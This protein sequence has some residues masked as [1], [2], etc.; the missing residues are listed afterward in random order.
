MY[1]SFKR[2][3]KVYASW[4]E[5]RS[6][7]KDSYTKLQPRF[8]IMMY[9]GEPIYSSDSIIQMM[10]GDHTLGIGDSMWIVSYLR[11]MWKNKDH[12]E[13]FH[14]VTTEY[15]IPFFKQFLPD[16]FTFHSEYIEWDKFAEFDHVLPGMY[17]WK[18]IADGADRSW[19][20][21]KSL[22][23]RMFM[24]AGVPYD[25]LPNWSEFTPQRIL[26]PDEAFYK[27]LGILKEDKYVFFQ[28]HSSGRP[29]NLPPAANIRI[30]RHI[31]K[32]YKLK[33]YIIGHLSCLGALEEIDGVVNLSR[34]TE[35][36]D[37]FSLAANAEFI[38][39]PDSAGV[40]LSEA[41]QVP[42]VC[43]MSVLPPSYIASKYKIPTF[44]FGRGHCPHKPCGVVGALPKDKCPTG[45]KNYCR[46]FDII[47]LVQFD[48]CVTK[49][50]SNILST[51]GKV[52]AHNFYDAMYCPISLVH[53]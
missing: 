8:D 52:T 34:K 46:V 3:N 9:K 45:T 24:W 12:N 29:K 49:S 33:V 14:F 18:E 10:Q 28:W 13:N 50:Y 41:Y 38:V 44:M 6:V 2:D 51:P 53:P 26:E 19:L 42:C 39:C 30:I 40:H 25:G 11:G 15:K 5:P 32:K 31:I 7:P 23:E 4:G 43:L 22:L 36:D 47:D 16:S 21:N 27:K 37:L 35:V 1:W 20:D 17:Y 48:D